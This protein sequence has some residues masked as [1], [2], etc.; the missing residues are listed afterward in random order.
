MKHGLNILTLILLLIVALFSISCEKDKDNTNNTDYD[1]YSFTDYNQWYQDHTWAASVDILASSQTDDFMIIQP[2]LNCYRQGSV[3]TSDQFLLTVNEEEIPLMF[4]LGNV[5]V[6]YSGADIYLDYASELHIV[7]KINGVDKVNKSVL[8]PSAITVN[9]PANLDFAN[10]VTISWSMAESPDYLETEVYMRYYY[11]TPAYTSKYFN[12]LVRS[13]IRSYTLPTDYYLD[14][15]NQTVAANLELRNAA[16]YAINFEEQ[17]DNVI[18][19][20]VFDSAVLTR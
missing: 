5:S 3:S 13:H 11:A 10:P 9:T 2:H 14:E 12:H 18:A 7:L 16:V 4:N 8:I 6:D 1:F 15:F 17:G 19:V 20:R